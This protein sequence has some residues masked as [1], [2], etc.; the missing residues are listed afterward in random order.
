[1]ADFDPVVMVWSLASRN[2]VKIRSRQRRRYRHRN[3]RAT[4]TCCDD[5][6]AMTVAARVLAIRAGMHTSVPEF[7]A[8]DVYKLTS[9][10]TL[11][12]AAAHTRQWN[13]GKGL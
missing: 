7:C 2:M 4:Y 13:R 8:R 6:V 9:E 5:R 10:L 1:V 11:V 3:A 12:R